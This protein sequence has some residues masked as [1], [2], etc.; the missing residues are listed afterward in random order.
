M[1]FV[2]KRDHSRG[3]VIIRVGY[4]YEFHAHLRTKQ[5]CRQLL[6][7]IKKGLL[8]KNEYL[9]GSCRRL[10]TEEEFN[11]LKKAK[12]KCIRSILF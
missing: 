2:I 3:W 12:D 7:F 8:P 4:P 10:L 11:K 5:G 9:V 1:E 6:N